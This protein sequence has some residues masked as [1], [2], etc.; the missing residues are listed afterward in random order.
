MIM[1]IKRSKTIVTR[2]KDTELLWY[3]H[4]CDSERSYNTFQLYECKTGRNQE[5]MVMAGYKVLYGYPHE[6]TWK[7]MKITV[8]KAS[9]KI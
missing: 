1:I 7:S 5:R 3:N 2:I 6:G 9:F 8:S 4:V